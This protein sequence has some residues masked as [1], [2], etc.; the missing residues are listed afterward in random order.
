[1]SYVICLRLA[2]TEHPAKTPN[3]HSTHVYAHAT[4]V[5]VHVR[6]RYTRHLT[7]LFNKKIGWRAK[8][9]LQGNV[10]KMWALRLS[11]EE[12]CQ[13]GCVESRPILVHKASHNGNSC[14]KRVAQ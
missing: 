1:M 13:R 12:I 10:L 2:A 5:H 7:N 3:T 8:H 14:E 9:G 11:H 4:H 6:S